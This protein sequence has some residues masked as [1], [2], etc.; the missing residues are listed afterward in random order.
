MNLSS[1]YAAIYVMAGD[2]I[3]SSVKS[4]LC[5]QCWQNVSLLH[6]A[7]CNHYKPTPRNKVN[8]LIAF[9]MYEM[10]VPHLTI[11]MKVTATL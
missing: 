5:Q 9:F 11:V 6:Q 3:D 4:L 7:L 1:L 2:A 10:D 8:S